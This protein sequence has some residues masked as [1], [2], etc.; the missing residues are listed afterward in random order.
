MRKYSIPLFLIPI[1]LLAPIQEEVDHR[2]Q[3]EE[4]TYVYGAE[5]HTLHNYHH[6]DEWSGVAWITA[7]KKSHVNAACFDRRDGSLYVFE[8][9]ADGDKPI[10]HVWEVI[11]DSDPIPRK[12]KKTSIRR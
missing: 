5:N 2:I 6:S 12:R 4:R 9:R 10:I 3:P 1:V 11:S 8:N 7:G